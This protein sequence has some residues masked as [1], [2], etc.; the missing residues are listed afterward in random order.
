MRIKK[1]LVA[2]SLLVASIFTPARADTPGQVINVT[3]SANDWLKTIVPGHA[4]TCTQPNYNNFAG[5]LPFPTTSSLGGVESLSCSAGQFLS[6]INTLGVPVCGTPSGAVVSVTASS[7]ILSSGGSTPNISIPKADTGTNGY[8]SSTDWNTFN[9]KQP[10]GTYVNS[11]SGTAP[12]VSSGGVTPAI[13]M[14]AATSSVNGY[15]TSSDWSLFNGKQN[16]LTFGTVSTTTTGLSI[17]S[18]ANST[19]GPNVTINVQTASSSQPGLLSAAD[20]TTF[21]SK[22]PAI[23]AGTT[24]Q[25]WRGDKSFQTLNTAIVPESGNLYFTNARAQ[26]AVSATAPIVDTSGVFSIPKATTSVDGYLAALDWT[27]FN[28]KQNALVFGS[29]STTTSGVT[30]GSGSNSTVGP[31]VTVDVQTASG[32]QPG[33][34]SA[35]DWATFNSKAN[36]FTPGSIST[37][38]TGVT[39]GSGSNSTVGPNVTVN[40]QNAS[41]SQPG[42]LTAADWNTFNGKQ[43]SGNYITALT[44]DVVASGPGSVAATIQSNV[45]SNVKLA[46]MNAN[47]L[48]GN[49]TGSTANA[50]DLSATQTTAMLN[51]FTSTL[52]GL[53]PGSGGGTTNFLRADG[54]FAA[55]TGSVTSVALSTP[56]VIFSVS[57]SPV[58][59]SGTL[60]LNLLTQS[61]NAFL[62]GPTSGAA[63][64]PTFRAMVQADQPAPIG[65]FGS[66]IDGALTISSGNTVLT[67]DV[68]YTNLT[69]S[70]TAKLAPAGYRIFVNGTCDFTAAP[71]QAI[72]VEGSVGSNGAAIATGGA[73]G[74]VAYSTAHSLGATQVG[75]TGGAGGVTT[76]VAGGQAAS[77]S[78]SNGGANGA[79]GKAGDGTGGVG[80]SGHVS[81]TPS[82]AQAFPRFETNLLSGATLTGGSNGGTG[83]SGG[84]GD[85]T[86][87]GSGAG[88]GGGGG[89]A[90][91]LACNKVLRTGAASGAINARAGNGGTAGSPTI[92]A[93]GAA[94]GGS[95]GGGGTIYFLYGTIL[96]ATPATGFFDVSGGGGGAGGTAISAAGGGASGGGGA[97]GRVDTFNMTAGTGTSFFGGTP[98]APNVASGVTGGA[99]VS[100]QSGLVTF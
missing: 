42:L 82:L 35:A 60:A 98:V 39:V 50:S 80:A 70:G 3:C 63:A 96:D 66:G 5:V 57:G 23:S 87:A 88:G 37:S 2:L 47:T 92:T 33:L 58:T 38:T 75:T 67:H 7:P 73:G 1:S 71:N 28:G 8:L 48:K 12:V 94:S 26:G 95:G 34:L 93:R 76:G 85:G 13:S 31:N 24:L 59:S 79:T 54:T 83:G 99:A 69:I 10:S 72:T 36:A 86:T 61:A 29:V 53:V 6:S 40:V 49:N 9:G 19:V 74:L 30:V 14:A 45:V 51:T 55:P 27:L 89:G 62:A 81:T 78:T 64:T 11:V 91:Y 18:G 20:W 65:V 52:Q 68:F 21:N 97:A 17:G 32:S 84:G 25:Y 43:A 16:A 44:S 15:L 100:G 46:Q 56:G 22:E 77:F 90:I 4:P 41:T